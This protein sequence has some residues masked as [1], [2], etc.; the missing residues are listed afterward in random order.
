LLLVV[1][2]VAYRPSGPLQVVGW[3]LLALLP[4]ASAALAMWTRIP[5]GV[6]IAIGLIIA[7]E[8]HE[9][10][11]NPFVIAI[12][13][14][15]WLVGGLLGSRQ[16][17]A[18]QL[19]QRARELD[20]EREIFA[21]ESVR[22]ERARIARELHDIVAHCVSVMV[23]QAAAGQRVV[24][25]DPAMAM[26]SLGNIAATAAQAQ[27]E[28]DRLVDLLDKNV[29]VAGDAGLRLVDELVSRAQ[30]TGIRITCRIAGSTDAVSNDAAEVVYR[31]VQ[32]SVTNALK[33]APGAAIEIEIRGEGGDVHVSVV[34]DEPAPG[35]RSLGALGGSHGLAGMRQRVQ[36][37]GGTLDAGPSAGGGWSVRA[38]VPRAGR[39]ALARSH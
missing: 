12:V 21:L 8:W 30:A 1:V 11:A 6:A 2:A 19:E 10:Y 7:V 4:V 14:G 15:P 23:I 29:T 18:D 5:L 35:V 36:G 31:V 37:C 28:M 9:G 38:T 22:N 13:V 25:N 16:R 27:A 39:V 34:N 24:D 20:E 17:L 32:E 33:H 3:L 26:E